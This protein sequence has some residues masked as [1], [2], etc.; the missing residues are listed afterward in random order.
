MARSLVF[1]IG[2]LVGVAVF[3]STMT[4]LELGPPSFF[5]KADDY[6]WEDW[7]ARVSEAISRE[8]PS[9]AVWA[10]ENYID[11]LEGRSELLEEDMWHRFNEERVRAYS[12]LAV[13]YKKM[14]DL[15]N[16]KVSVSKAL[17][18]SKR[19]GRKNLTN[20]AD[21]LRFAQ[22]RGNWERSGGDPG[23]SDEE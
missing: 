13:V 2:A 3:A 5:Q 10:L 4:H 23:L 19:Y 6:Y 16:Y 14:G 22:T 1:F 17:S 7:S 20:E 12:K 9:I 21:I 11:R 8:E 15:E 18:L